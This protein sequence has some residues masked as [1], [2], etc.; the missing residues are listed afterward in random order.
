MKAPALNSTSVMK[1]DAAVPM[2]ASVAVSENSV[3][4]VLPKDSGDGKR[5]V[6][7]ARRQVNLGVSQSSFPG[8]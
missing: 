1:T 7:P 2:E 5:I 4:P 6:I 8:R 3:I